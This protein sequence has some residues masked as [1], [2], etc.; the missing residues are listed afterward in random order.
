MTVPHLDKKVTEKKLR[1][2]L[3]SSSHFRFPFF[4]PENP[5]RKNGLFVHLEETLME[6]GTK[7]QKEYGQNFVSINL[8][9]SW[10]RGIP[11]EDDD[12]DLLFIIRNL[13]V[14]EQFYIQSYCR[15][16]LRE[17]NQ[18]YKVCEGKVE[19]GIRVDPI[20]FL[21]MAKMP[22]IMSLFMY[23]LRYFLVNDIKEQR[24]LYQESFFG[25]KMQEKLSKFVQSGILIPYVGWIYGKWKKEE[26]FDE[27]ATFLPIPS[28]RTGLYGEDEVEMTK[29]I[30]RQTFVA[31]NLIYPAIK[32]KSFIS[33]SEIYVP[34]FKEEALALYRTIEPLKG[35]HARA[36]I[37]YLYASAL[38]L[39]LFGRRFIMDR[40]EKF[41]GHYDKLVH[42]I[43]TVKF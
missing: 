18:I 38:E 14:K 11:L 25:S 15:Q 20:T 19:D 12:I 5:Y 8:R 23:G 17:K 33:P 39:K 1:F 13:P 6:A 37:N 35:I 21:D 16:A 4:D 10:L 27:I 7:F 32:L 40:V 36:I 22:T 28:R 41:A 9:G 2:Y 42:Y 3:E 34:E 29:E 43:L 24:D 31:R 30:L 26:I